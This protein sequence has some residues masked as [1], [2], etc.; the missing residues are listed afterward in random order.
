MYIC[1]TT[2]SGVTFSMTPRNR[3]Q[4]AVRLNLSWAMLRLSARCPDRKMFWAMQRYT[5]ILWS[6]QTS[7]FKKKNTS[8]KSHQKTLSN[9]W[10]IKNVMNG[11]EWPWM[12]WA[13]VDSNFLVGQKH[14]VKKHMTKKGPDSRAASDIF[15]LHASPAIS[16]PV[17]ENSGVN[18]QLFAVW[19]LGGEAN[20]CSK[21]SDYLPI[22]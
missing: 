11:W 20:F 9:T 6:I 2:R 21:Q 17:R 1:N 7:Y 13:W 15:F 22:Y 12:T 14:P 10:D 16:S 3:I 19:P 4:G 5:M 8:K 18:D